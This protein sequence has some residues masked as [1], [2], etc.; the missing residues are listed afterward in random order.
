MVVLTTLG[1]EA[2]YRSF[3]VPTMMAAN[4]VTVMISDIESFSVFL[5]FLQNYLTSYNN[6]TL[7][8]TYSFQQKSTHRVFS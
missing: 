7:G 2:S 3:V 6:Y 4:I 5:A 1:A 8:E